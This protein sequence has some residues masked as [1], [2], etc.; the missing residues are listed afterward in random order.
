MPKKS[1][2]AESMKEHPLTSFGETKE[3]MG[4]LRTDLRREH[5]ILGTDKDP[6][7]LF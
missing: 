4:K 1:K 5:Y 6:K 2:Y 7:T 3:E